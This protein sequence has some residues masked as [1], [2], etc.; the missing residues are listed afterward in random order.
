MNFLESYKKEVETELKSILAYWA[1]YAIDEVNGGFYGFVNVQNEPDRLAA[2][3]L[4]LNARI[5]W[6]FSAAYNYSKDEKYLQLAQRAYNY[7]I[8]YFSDK[9]YGGLFWSL[10][11]QGKPLNTRKQIYGQAFA[12]YGLSEYY[13]ASNDSKSLQLA[14]E[15]F[16]LLEKNSFDSQKGGYLEALTQDWQT[17]ED[18]RLSDK[19]ANEQ[20]TMNTHLH[21]LEAYTN[22][23][24]VWANISL[25]KQ[26]EALLEVFQTYMIDNE[27]WHQHLFLTENWEVKSNII[28]YGHDIEAAWLLYEA[29]EVLDNEVLIEKIQHISLQL[30]QSTKQ[31]FDV[32]NGMNYELSLD[33]LHL[34]TDKHWWVQAEA[35]V[36]FMNAFQLSGDE[37]FLQ[38][39][40]QSWLF[41]KK[42]IID[43]KNGEWL[44]GVTS[45]YKPINDTKIGFWKCP[46]HNVRACLEISKR[47]TQIIA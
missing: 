40:W 12:I 24:R 9:E 3:G 42:R 35:M 37:S 30:S 26:I 34:D 1:K 29:A 5:L 18:V 22:L 33:N 31:G 36:G 41:I 27:K 6:T 10:D 17:M 4:V 47:I 13:K 28:S 14:I 23:Y 7:L 20:K 25:K 21:I 15:L 39:S 43:D 11:Y 19:D 2:K 44:W 32:D 45:D 46:Y 38:K 8:Q 16:Q